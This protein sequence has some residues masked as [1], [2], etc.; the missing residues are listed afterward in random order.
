MINNTDPAIREAGLAFFYTIAK[1]DGL[2]EHIDKLVFNKIKGWIF[3]KIS[4]EWWRFSIWK[5][6]RRCIWWRQWWWR[7]SDRVCINKNVIFRWKSCCN[8]CFGSFFCSSTIIVFKLFLKDFR[9]ARS[10]VIFNI[11]Y[12]F[13]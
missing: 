8:L 9:Y 11:S 7:W 1:I 2:A 13:F 5:V 3:F 6:K 10:K 4:N 12:N